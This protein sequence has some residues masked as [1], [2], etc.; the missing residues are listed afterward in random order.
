MRHND[1]GKCL[2]IW[3][4][5]ELTEAFQTVSSSLAADPNGF[6]VAELASTGKL[7]SIRQHDKLAYL[8]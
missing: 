6:F 1:I 3:S 7:N 2:A 5:V 4:R 8:S